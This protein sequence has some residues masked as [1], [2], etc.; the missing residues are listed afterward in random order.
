MTEQLK[1][2]A[3][4]ASDQSETDILALTTKGRMVEIEILTLVLIPQ[5]GKLSG[6]RIKL[7]DKLLSKQGKTYG[8]RKGNLRCRQSRGQAELA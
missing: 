4:L 5:R 2:D 1:N 3:F 8:E 7:L 6:P